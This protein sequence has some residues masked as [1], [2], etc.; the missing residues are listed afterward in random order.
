MC[1]AKEDLEHTHMIFMYLY[2]LTV[3]VPSPSTIMEIL[4]KGIFYEILKNYWTNLAERSKGRLYLIGLKL[5]LLFT[6]K[7]P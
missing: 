1:T 7:N 4:W 6:P 2:L 3:L 5:G